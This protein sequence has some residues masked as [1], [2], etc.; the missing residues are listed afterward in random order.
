MRIGWQ[1]DRKQFFKMKEQY[2]K[3]AHSMMSIRFNNTL[4][5]QY[6]AIDMKYHVGRQSGQTLNSHPAR[7]EKMSQFPAYP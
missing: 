3:K 5:K 2:V 4:I 7:Y 1:G 6:P